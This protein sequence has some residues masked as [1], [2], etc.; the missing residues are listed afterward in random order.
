MRLMP[1][2]AIDTRTFNDHLLNV[3]KPHVLLNL[4]N[5]LVQRLKFFLSDI[6]L[7]NR[8]G[9]NSNYS[10][11]KIIL[12]IMESASMQRK[13]VISWIYPQTLIFMN[14]L[15]TAIFQKIPLLWNCPIKLEAT[16]VFRF[17]PRVV[18]VSLKVWK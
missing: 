11:E 6:Q 5:L 17:W 16:Q 9:I 13:T 2:H 14:L 7:R 1:W 10:F 8:R 4:A 18:A 12:T 3:W 15:W